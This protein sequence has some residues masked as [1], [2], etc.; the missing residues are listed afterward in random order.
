MAVATGK[1]VAPIVCLFLSNNA[2]LMIVEKLL[3]YRLMP[4]GNVHP[5][6]HSACT[7]RKVL[8][9]IVLS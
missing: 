9:M 2:R 4:V 8:P 5:Q 3:Y 6:H 1:M 7:I